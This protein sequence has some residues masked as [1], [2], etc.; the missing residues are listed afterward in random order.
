MAKI[1]DKQM[2]SASLLKEVRDRFLQQAGR[3]HLFIPYF[4]QPVE[5][6]PG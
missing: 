1:G 6:S 5:G 2:F 3:K 4:C